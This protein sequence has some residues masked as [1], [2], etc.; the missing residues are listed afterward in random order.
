MT[1]N[2]IHHNMELTPAIKQYAEEKMRGLLKYMDSIQHMDVE[3]GK[4]TRHHHKGDIFQCVA[5]AQIGGEVLR[6]ERD[7]D[8]LYKAIDLVKD[9]LREDIVEFKK[10]M[11]DRRGG[12]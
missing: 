6:V 12:V 8:D 1:I 2:L 3:L 7:E 11:E 10:R 5:R 4:S 9:K